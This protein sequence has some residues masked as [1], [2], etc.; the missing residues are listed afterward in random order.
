MGRMYT[1]AVSLNDIMYR[2]AGFVKGLRWLRASA[3]AGIATLPVRWAPA[4][5]MKL[6]A[7]RKMNAANERKMLW[8]A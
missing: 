6:F 3:A 4:N 1:P 5:Q 8:I 7:S 2:L